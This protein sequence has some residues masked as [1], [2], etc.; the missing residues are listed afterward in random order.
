[1]K[2]KSW[3]VVTLCLVVCNL[4]SGYTVILKSGKHIEGTLL[5]EDRDVIRLKDQQGT[6]LVFKKNMLDLEA[7]GVSP[8]SQISHPPEL[9]QIGSQPGKERLWSVNLFVS[10]AYDTN[11]NHDAEE[12]HSHG[13]IYGSE[14]S[15][16]T[17]AIHPSL[18]LNYE[19]AQN[20]YTNTDAWDR[21]SHDFV[22]T[23]EKRMS[24]AVTFELDGELNFRGSSEDRELSNQYILEPHINYRFT[25][26]TRLD[27]YGAYRLKRYDDITRNSRN[28]YVGIDFQRFLNGKEFVAGIRHERNDADGERNSYIRW[29]YT[30]SYSTAFASRNLFS[31]ELRFRPQRYE[32]RLIKVDGLEV[33]R[34]D[35]R[36]ILNAS[37]VLSIAQHFDLMPGY[38]LETRSSNDPDKVFTAHLTAL[39][40][41]YHW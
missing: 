20:S 13:F 19:I 30:V 17:A 35:R 15:Y 21:V 40:L 23:Y 4:A 34:D 28:K 37:F 32:H 8:S 3:L 6:I 24:K 31:A 36:W 22:A 2:T 33:L 41:R 14:V 9:P 27:F 11:I 5:D 26:E 39:A 38:R 1:M 12:V 16:Q 7:M 25:R 29:T 10:N 18:K